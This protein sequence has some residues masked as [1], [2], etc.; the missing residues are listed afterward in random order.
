MGK[1]RTLGIGAALGGVVA[2]VVWRSR[3]AR[4][5]AGRIY[6]LVPRPRGDVDDVTLTHKVQSELF[7]SDDRVRGSVVV[8]TANGVVQLRGEVGSTELIEELVARTRRVGGVKDVESL[9]HVPGTDAPM[10]Q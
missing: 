4:A 3:R 5:L 1:G 2:I 8:N 10:H 7:G 9:L 6:G